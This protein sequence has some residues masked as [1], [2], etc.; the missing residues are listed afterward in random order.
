MGLATATSGSSAT[1]ADRASVE[2]GARPA[3]GQ[4]GIAGERL[5]RLRELVEGRLI[6]ELHRIA[7]RDAQSNCKDRNEHA[8]LVTPEGGEEETGGVHG[9]KVKR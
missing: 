2:A 3:D 8:S 7:Q 6:D 4:V 9:V 1:L 5:Q